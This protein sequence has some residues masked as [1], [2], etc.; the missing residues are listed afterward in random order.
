[1]KLVLLGCCLTENFVAAPR[2]VVLLLSLLTEHVADVV[3]VLLLE[4]LV[5]DQVW[6]DVIGDQLPPFLAVLE[7][8]DSYN[9]GP[10]GDG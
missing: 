3:P 1:M 5:N 4:L 9:T 7:P 2:L 6:H 8:L 10:R